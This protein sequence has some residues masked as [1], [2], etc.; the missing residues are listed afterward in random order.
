MQNV[1]FY[2]AN[3]VKSKR[4]EEYSAFSATLRCGVLFEVS[5][6]SP[7]LFLQLLI[8]VVLYRRLAWLEFFHLT[9]Q[10]PRTHRLATYQ[11]KTLLLHINHVVTVLSDG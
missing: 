3:N 2:R 7:I 11:P 8:A 4:E 10:V 9:T 5:F 6:E 1:S